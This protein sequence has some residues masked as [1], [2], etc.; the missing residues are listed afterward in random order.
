V[1]FYHRIL[2]CHVLIELKVGKFSYADTGQLTTYLNYFK[3]EMMEP[4]DNPPIGILLMTE[5]DKDGALAKY[6]IPPGMDQQMFISTYAV[7]LPTV[8]EL[9]QCLAAEL[10]RCEN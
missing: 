1:V 10:R 2:K 3:A 8:E 6:A 7:Q 4:G 5:R 9:Q